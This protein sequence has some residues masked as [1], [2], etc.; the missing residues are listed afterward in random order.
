[1]QESNQQTPVEKP[2]LAFV[3]SL[4]AG[5]WM[6]VVVSSF[7]SLIWGLIVVIAAIVLYFNPQ[8]RR[9]SGL[10]I[11][12]VSALNFPFLEGSSLSLLTANE[13]IKGLA[14]SLGVVGGAWGSLKG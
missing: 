12:I 10:V 7:W 2:W 14:A 1:M 9:Q 13:I 4:L 8:R 5:L 3:L 11:M 6:L